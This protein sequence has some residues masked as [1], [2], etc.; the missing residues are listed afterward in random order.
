MSAMMRGTITA[1]A[2]GRAEMPSP[3]C[4]KEGM[5]FMDAVRSLAEMAG[6]DVPNTGPL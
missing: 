3:F 2:A 5:A 4:V 6:M 1:L